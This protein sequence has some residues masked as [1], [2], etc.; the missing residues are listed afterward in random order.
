MS[1]YNPENPQ[2]PE[3]NAVR[4]H[5]TQIINGDVTTAASEWGFATPE[6][7][8]EEIDRRPLLFMIGAGVLLFFVALFVVFQF[9]IAPGRDVA[10]SPT[11]PAENISASTAEPESKTS[12]EPSAEATE[13][14]HPAQAV[15]E[16]NLASVQ[17]I[18]NKSTCEDATRDAQI[19]VD[20]VNSAIE[21]DSWN[22]ENQ[23]IV[24]DK[25]AE[26][27][28]HCTNV[29]HKQNSTKLLELFVSG[30]VPA[31]LEQITAD[32]AW[33]ADAMQIPA[34][35]VKLANGQSFTTA[36]GNIHCVFGESSVECTIDRY[37]ANTVEQCPGSGPATFSID[38]NGST[39][40][41]CDSRVSAQT[42][43][44]YDTPYTNGIFACEIGKSSGFNCWHG[45][46]GHGFQLRQQSQDVY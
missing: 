9:L 20:F 23:T 3:T 14:A 27:D 16:E 2:S 37:N 42:Q 4:T 7:R 8:V 32:G 44:E 29:G 22:K 34:N 38:A 11:T 31:E 10:E 46:T 21:T 40:V 5:E 25:L 39:S 33:I 35:A 1:T 43:A 24:T 41:S 36:V 18:T 15:F 45:T 30:S 13:S 17:D 6:A 26:L 28:S 19:F 12:K